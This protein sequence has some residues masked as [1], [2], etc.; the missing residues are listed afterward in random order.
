M[1]RKDVGCFS[2]SIG[3]EMSAYKQP[4]GCWNIYGPAIDPRLVPREALRRESRRM[5]TEQSPRP[6]RPPIWPPTTDLGGRFEPGM[7]VNVPVGSK[8]YGINGRWLVEP[9]QRPDTWLDA[10]VRVG[11]GVMVAALSAAL[12]TA[13]ISQ[14]GAVP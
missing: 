8:G 10:I 6:T 11:L 4:D 7:V 13:L 12:T 14:H 5:L 3:I 2:W 1:I 9:V